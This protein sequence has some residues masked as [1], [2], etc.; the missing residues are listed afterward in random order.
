MRQAGFEF[1]AARGEVAAFGFPRRP[2]VRGGFSERAAVTDERRADA[3]AAQDGDFFQGVAFG[4]ECG[5]FGLGG[6]AGSGGKGGE[7]EGLFHDDSGCVLQ[8]GIAVG[9][10]ARHFTPHCGVLWVFVVLRQKHPLKN[11]VLCGF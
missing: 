8:V 4:R 3:V 1:A 2:G 7:E 9:G 6:G 10:N 5:A 11:E